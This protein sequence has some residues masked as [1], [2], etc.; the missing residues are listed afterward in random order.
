ME[1]KDP[2]GRGDSALSNQGQKYN[3]HARQGS[4][5]LHRVRDARE[6]T[7][8][9]ERRESPRVEPGTAKPGNIAARAPLGS[10]NETSSPSASTFRSPGERQPF[11]FYIAVD[12]AAGSTSAS[13][14]VFG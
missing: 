2:M 9:T 1:E 7:G 11:D 14:L 5:L 6:W 12:G 3:R 8:S 10:S 4:P 13:S